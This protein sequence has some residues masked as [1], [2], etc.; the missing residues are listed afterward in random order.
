[1]LARYVPIV[2]TFAPPVAGA[3][4]MRYRRFVTYSIL[5]GILWVWSMV[6]IGFSLGSAI[7]NV[8]KH[9]HVI[10]AIIIFLSILPPVIETI[11]QRR[12]NAAPRFVPGTDR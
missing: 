9:I 2:R 11:R 1:M 3:A 8:D 5:G 4:G 12:Q 6:L 7:P 10:I